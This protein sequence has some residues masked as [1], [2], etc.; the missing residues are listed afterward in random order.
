MMSNVS[1]LKLSSTEKNRDQDINGF[2]HLLSS[3]EKRR[4]IVESMKKTLN[5]FVHALI[6][7]PF[8]VAKRKYIDKRDHPGTDSAI[9]SQLFSCGVAVNETSSSASPSRSSSA[10]TVDINNHQ[11]QH[12][13][14][15]DDLDDND[16]ETNQS[17]SNTLSDGRSDTTTTKYSFK[18]Q[19]SASVV[20]PSLQESIQ[21]LDT[22]NLSLS[23]QIVVATLVHQH[24]S[25]KNEEDLDFDTSVDVKRQHH[26]LHLQQQHPQ[27][28]IENQ[29]NQ[30]N[31]LIQTSPLHLHHH[32]SHASPP[33]SFLILNRWRQSQENIE[34]YESPLPSPK[35]QH[36][37]LISSNVF[38]LRTT[39]LRSSLPTPLYHPL[40]TTLRTTS[41]TTTNSLTRLSYPDTDANEI[42]MPSSHVIDTEPSSLVG[43]RLPITPP[44]ISAISLDSSCDKIN[45]ETQFPTFNSNFQHHQ[46]RHST[47]FLPTK[48]S[49]Y[50]F[51]AIPTSSTAITQPTIT[52]SSLSTTNLTSSNHIT[53]NIGSTTTNT[54]TTTGVSGG[55]N[56]RL[57]AL[58]S[59]RFANLFLP[60]H[61]HHH[62]HHHNHNPHQKHLHQQPA[63]QHRS[64]IDFNE[65][66]TK[67]NF[68]NKQNE[69]AKP[70]SHQ[71]FLSLSLS[72]PLN[73]R[74]KDLPALRG[75]FVSFMLCIIQHCDLF[76]N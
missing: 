76:V 68:Y 63:T 56:E 62:H 25:R 65:F 19:T 70:K 61:H 17:E 22:T 39:S 44:P 35:Q 52:S 32:S 1:N 58:F 12:N 74:N 21:N 43:V 72:P 69:M 34:S 31:V 37:S 30:A 7:T 28:E 24:P 47:S 11:Q 15:D 67:N 45:N 54:T 40:S 16:R 46:H 42:L 50:S 3:R 18:S 41:I 14:T 9:N 64:T 71:D 53:S 59:G 75:P 57:G 4:F 26:L 10:N 51:M 55:I 8:S 20:P 60:H 48:T 49:S 27:V 2:R 36:E 29:E 66:I 33:R 38:P 13:N 5:H 6:R 23:Q 73:R